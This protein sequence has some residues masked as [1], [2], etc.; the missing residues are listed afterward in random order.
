[1]R[2]WEEN[3]RRTYRLLCGFKVLNEKLFTRICRYQGIPVG[4]TVDYLLRRKRMLRWRTE[5]GWMVGIHREE[6]PAVP[7]MREAATVLADIMSGRMVEEVMATGDDMYLISFV[8]EGSVY[9]ICH[10]TEHRIK[11][12]EQGAGS[13]FILVDDIGYI[14]KIPC[15]RSDLF[16]MVKGGAVEYYGRK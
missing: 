4:K 11:E 14:R 1:M 15:Q 12:Y 2:T 7:G 10:V 3:V 16:C 8:M 5:N 6:S 9:D 13:R